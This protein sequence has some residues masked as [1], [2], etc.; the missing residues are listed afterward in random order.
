VSRGILVEWMTVKK[1][2]FDPPPS[3]DVLT[4]MRNFLDTIFAICYSVVAFNTSKLHLM[5]HF[6]DSHHSL[7][8]GLE[9]LLAFKPYNQE[10]GTVELS[11]IYI[12]PAIN[13]GAF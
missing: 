13:G 9:V 10:M 7:S 8:R 2:G 6:V 3:A 5:L 11:E 4:R 12:I 1:L